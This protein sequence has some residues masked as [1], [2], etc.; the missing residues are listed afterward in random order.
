M[1]L[2]QPVTA[3]PLAAALAQPPDPSQDRPSSLA[4]R[5][6]GFVRKLIDYG[7]ERADT[8]PLQPPSGEAGI[9][10]KIRFGILRFGRKT[11]LRILALIAHA[12]RLAAILEDRL[13]GRPARRHTTAQLCPR[14]VAARPRRPAP[15]AATAGQR[16]RA[17][18]P[19]H[20]PIDFLLLLICTELGLCHGD[21]LWEEMEVP[22]N[23]HRDN[24]IE[25]FEQTHKQQAPTNAFA[26]KGFVPNTDSDT[27]APPV[28]KAPVPQARPALHLVSVATAATGP[29]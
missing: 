1:L 14:A 21:K 28:P 24:L 17:R 23:E 13:A 12:L 16:H 3:T 15:R 11:T 20:L 27:D 26:P 8:L 4:T 5:T 18:T 7:R 29:P 19:F 22:V 2:L 10:L 6:L 25:S 9:D